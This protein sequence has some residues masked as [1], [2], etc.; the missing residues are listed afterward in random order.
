MK[1]AIVV[2]NFLL[3]TK[4]PYTPT[5]KIIKKY[6]ID[7]NHTL[8]HYDGITYREKERIEK[9]LGKKAKVIL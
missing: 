5:D 3:G 2:N 9:I 1:I 7:R 8:L 6:R 4:V